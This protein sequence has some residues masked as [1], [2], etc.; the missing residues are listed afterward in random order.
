MKIRYVR[1][2]DGNYNKNGG[3]SKGRP[4]GV[5]V[6]SDNGNYGYAFWNPHLNGGRIDRKFMI[7]LAAGRAVLGHKVKVPS[8][9][10]QS[11]DWPTLYR[12]LE[13]VVKSTCNLI[14]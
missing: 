2:F 9:S 8:R 14:K 7:E 1:E 12:T 6:K 10:I 11:P 5:V 13:D 4:V 3:F